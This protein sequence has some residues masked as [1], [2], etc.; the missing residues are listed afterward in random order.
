MHWV[1]Q[2]NIYAEAGF[3]RLIEVLTR[4]GL[5]H[6]IHKCI[7]FVGT[8]EPVPEPVQDRV[9]VMGSY[10]L[11]KVAEQRGWTPGAF[12]NENFDYQVQLQHWNDLMVNHDAVF[13]KIADVPEQSVPFFIRPVID[14]KSFSG[15]VTDWP[16][17]EEWRQ[18][19]SM[20]IPEDHATAD[21]TT[22]VMVAPVKPIYAEYRVWMVD[23]KAVAWSQ[24]K[25]VGTKLVTDAVDR[26]VMVFAMQ[27]AQMWS[28]HRAYVLDVFSTDAGYKIGEVNNLNAAGW[29]GADMN[30]LVIALEEA[31]G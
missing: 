25:R 16:S 15:N 12:L 4:L 3:N 30:K 19:L 2:N 23:G 29:Y 1:I 7:P 27:A 11:A 26:S 10:T 21:L 6:S 9:I 13:C 5:P 22:D 8:L 20:L 14:S 24:Y 28:P 31:F 18:G 17:F